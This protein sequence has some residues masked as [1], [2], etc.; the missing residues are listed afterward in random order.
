MK[1]KILAALLPLTTTATIIAILFEVN[2]PKIVLEGGL[3]FGILVVV[4]LTSV[5]LLRMKSK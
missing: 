3:L 4:P 1:N 5:H 2:L